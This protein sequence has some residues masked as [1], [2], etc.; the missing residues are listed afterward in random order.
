MK[1]RKLILRPFAWGFGVVAIATVLSGTRAGAET[2]YGLGANNTLVTFDS[3]NP[4]LVTTRPILG[5]DPLVGI[6]FRP[7]NGVLY[8]MS[9]SRFLYTINLTSGLA[10]PVSG[11]PFSASAAGTSF[12]FDFNPT[13]DRIRIV[14]DAA[15][16]FRA[17]PDTGTALVD[18]TLAY[19]VGD[20][21]FGLDPTI[22][23]AAYANNFAGSSLSPLLVLDARLD[24]LAR[25]NPANSGVLTTIGFLGVNFTGAGGFDV[26]GLSGTAYAALTPAAGGGSQLYQIN[27]A[28]GAATSLGAIG[29]GGNL[30]GLAAPVPE[31]STW[32][33]LVAGI[34]CFF[35][36]TRWR[37]STKK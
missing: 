26:S 16:N 32:A 2:L 12:G 30:V 37:R 31:P 28:S 18:G 24:T 3:A 5:A 7:A 19:A 33:M 21:A 22:V 10:S 11:T 27:V 6:D 9:S 15:E 13:V 34:G 20:T 25:Q 36:M 23:G 17:N 1:T 29:F 8:G 4:A 35:G 14:N